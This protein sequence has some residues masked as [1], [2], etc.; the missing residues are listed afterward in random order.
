[1]VSTNSPTTSM[2]VE[3][4]GEE[5]RFQFDLFDLLYTLLTM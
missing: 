2:K 3:G 4:R 5:N 1:M